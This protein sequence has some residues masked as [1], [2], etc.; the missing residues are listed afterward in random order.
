M[1][2]ENEIME[3]L[4]QAQKP[5]S[6]ES[7]AYVFLQKREI[8]ISQGLIDNVLAGKIEAFIPEGKFATKEDG[9]KAKDPN[10][11]SFRAVQ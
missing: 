2:E 11:Y 9:Q 7:I 3:I 6:Q 8:K 4:K 5:L 1:S 10:A